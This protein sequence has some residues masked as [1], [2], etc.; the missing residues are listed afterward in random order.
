VL[1]AGVAGFEIALYNL[2]QVGT[3]ASGGP[4]VIGNECPAGT[5]WWV[6]LLIFSALA[7]AASTLGLPIGESEEGRAWLPVFAFVP[8]TRE[9]ALFLPLT[10]IVLLAAG[11]DTGTWIAA[12]ILVLAGPIL[13]LGMRW[14]M[15]DTDRVLAERRRK[16][17]RDRA[18][19]R[20]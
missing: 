16:F 10:A 11:T 9:S 13:W 5:G 8:G 7:T 18:R 1:V 15:A 12:G 20:T 2:A 4:Y 14:L 6:A 19:R 17:Q 3:C